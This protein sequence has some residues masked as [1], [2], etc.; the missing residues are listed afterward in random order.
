MRAK[1]AW[2]GVPITA[3]MA[4]HTDLVPRINHTVSPSAGRAT[5]T[6][7]LWLEVESSSVRR[8]YEVVPSSQRYATRPAGVA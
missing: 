4:R 6:H 7:C 5:Q 3:A 2:A 1:L 8:S